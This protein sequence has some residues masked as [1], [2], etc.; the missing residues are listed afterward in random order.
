MAGLMVEL[1]AAIKLW[2]KG[3]DTTPKKHLRTS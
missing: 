1:S 3:A 2:H